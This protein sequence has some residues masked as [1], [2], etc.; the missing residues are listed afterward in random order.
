VAGK[1]LWANRSTATRVT[2][3]TARRA[4]YYGARVNVRRFLALACLAAAPTLAQTQT[5]RAAVT[6]IRIDSR[7]NLPV[8]ATVAPA[9]PGAISPCLYPHQPYYDELKALLLRAFD[10]G[11]VCT[12]EWGQ[13]DSM[14]NRA[15]IDALACSAPSHVR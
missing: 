12:F 2:D 15:R 4:S 3:V 1:R 8:C 14:S 10:A 11:A 7:A 5:H 6:Q 9:M 13:V